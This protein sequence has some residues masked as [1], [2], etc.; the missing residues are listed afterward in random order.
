MHEYASEN[1]VWKIAAILSRV[2]ELILLDW[3][4]DSIAG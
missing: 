3:L 4:K 2:D 1:I